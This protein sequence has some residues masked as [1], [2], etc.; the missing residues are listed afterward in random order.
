VKRATWTPG[1]ATLEYFPAALSGN[2]V[3]GVAAP[4]LA[5]RAVVD[6]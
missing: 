5:R 4:P 6:A 3:N 1:P 2:T